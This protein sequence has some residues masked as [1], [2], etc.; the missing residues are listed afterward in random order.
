MDITDRQM[1]ELESALAQLETLDPADLPEPA[2]H[3][4]SLL[5]SILEQADSA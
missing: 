4:A 5:A 2:A 3:L 1:E